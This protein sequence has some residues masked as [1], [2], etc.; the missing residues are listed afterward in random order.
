MAA[1]F[2]SADVVPLFADTQPTPMQSEYPFFVNADITTRNDYEF[3]G[4]HLH[5]M[6]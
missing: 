6:N 5:V 4:F 2:S 3:H 1:S